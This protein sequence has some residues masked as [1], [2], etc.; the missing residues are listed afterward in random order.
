MDDMF[1]HSGGASFPLNRMGKTLV[2]S[3]CRMC[4]TLSCSSSPLTRG[5]FYPPMYTRL[6]STSKIWHTLKGP[7]VKSAGQRKPSLSRGFGANIELS[8][9][10]LQAG[11]GLETFS[12]TLTASFQRVKM[13]STSTRSPWTSSMTP[14][15]EMLL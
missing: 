9:T 5:L 1:S 2:I 12:S 10:P 8:F 6:S 13:A 11:A 3:L 7:A 15:L 14:R 4:F